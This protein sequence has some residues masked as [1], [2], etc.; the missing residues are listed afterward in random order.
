MKKYLTRQHIS[1]AKATRLILPALVLCALAFRAEAQSNIVGGIAFGTNSP[2]NEATILSVSNGTGTLDIGYIDTTK[3]IITNVISGYISITNNFSGTLEIEGSLS[4]SSLM[5]TNEKSALSVSGGTGVLQIN[6]GEYAGAN[7]IN[8]S[9][10]NGGWAAEF[11]DV[12]T[13]N[14]QYAS[15]SGGQ[16]GSISTGYKGSDAI[17]ATNS[18]LYFYDEGLDSSTVTGGSGFFGASGGNALFADS[19]L[20]V[21][22]NGTFIGGA[23][24]DAPS[25]GHAIWATN[26]T[27]TIHEGTFTA[28]HEDSAAIVLHN[29][30]L[31][32][33]GGTLNSAGLLGQT[34]SNQINHIT[35]SGGELSALRLE[36]SGTNNLIIASNS[37]TITDGI[38]QYGGTVQIDN[39]FNDP[40]QMIEL[41]DGAMIF[42]HDFALTNG[43]VFELINTNAFAQFQG[44]SVESNALFHVQNGWLS[45]SNNLQI[46]TEGEL[47]Y[48]I[49]DGE[50]GFVNIN[51]QTRFETNAVLKIDSINAAHT[52]GTNVFHLL[53]ADGGIYLGLTGSTNATTATFSNV[54][55]VVH[56]LSEN[57]NIA[58]RTEA[59]AIFIDTASHNLY[60]TFYTPTLRVW[61]N[62]DGQLGLL[63]DDI[64][65]ISNSTMN[66]LINS[67]GASASKKA[68]E[69]TYFTVQNNMQ[70]VL[71]GHDAAVG[72]ALSRGS[73]F[74]EVLTLQPHGSKGPQARGDEI[75]PWIKYYGQ[76][77][78]H[79]AG[80]NLSGYDSTLHGGVLG[81][82]KSFG[83]LLVGIMGGTGNYQIDADNNTD[84][85][86]NAYH[87]A[88]YTTLGNRKGYI[89]AGAAYGFYRTT[90]RTRTPFMLEGKYDSSV[91]SAYLGGG[92]GF[93]YDKAGTILTP[94]VSINY[95]QYAQ[96]AHSEAGINAV[97]R[98]FENFDADSLRTKIGL[99]FASFK[100]VD[101]KHFS[102]KWELRAHWLHELNPDPGSVNFGLQGGSNNYTLQHPS[103]Q[104][105]LYKGGFGLIFRNPIKEEQNV[106]LRIDFD[107]LFGDG[108]NSHNLSAK[109]TYAF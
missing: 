78:S 89:E 40:L 24:T 92:Y 14:I 67:M 79:D 106:V 104:E 12:G 39:N 60:A 96:D 62:A 91:V 6:K 109:V 11:R 2:L 46:K 26:S 107:E 45:A 57:T 80:T 65:A 97:P 69:E 50:T 83:K 29:S 98:I 85:N 1:E 71:Q 7:I 102:M 20:I 108:F 31:T 82:D 103:L 58:A 21:I 32:L 5:S 18:T 22:S 87:G 47:R 68:V 84:S 88:L 4:G 44:L 59:Q 90:A 95:A 93:E 8:N 49:A 94:E 99:N 77:A 101:Y 25:S 61:W 74:R 23:G 16:Y 76:F 70:V 64:D 37:V 36:G 10:T 28:G 42:A 43:G 66:I 75:H 100:S 3:I 15:F 13:V 48:T 27:L 17:Y 34:A 56:V 38:S 81:V 9:A 72:Q 86:I 41:N 73:D 35:L 54:V 105:D 53:T 19:S 63:A 55:Q 51:G 52:P 33:S 30:D